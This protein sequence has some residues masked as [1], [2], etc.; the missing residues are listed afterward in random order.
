MSTDHKK[1]RSGNYEKPKMIFTPSGLFYLS[2]LTNSHVLEKSV[3][4]NW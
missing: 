1:L 4:T 3:K 2:I